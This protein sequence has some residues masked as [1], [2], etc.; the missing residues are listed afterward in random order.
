MHD[1]QM[2]SV[3]PARLLIVGNPDSVHVGSHFQRAAAAMQIE[4]RVCDPREA[5]NAPAWRQKTDW[6]IRGHRP[7]RLLQ[8]SGRVLQTVRSF[9]PDA[10]LTTGIAPVDAETLETIGELGS[11]RLNFLTDDPWNP[12]HRAPWFLDALPAY[13]HVFTPRQANVA[14]LEAAGIRG[15][16]ILPFAYA[17]DVH[18]PETAP[19]PDAETYE[20]DVMVAGGGDRDRVE[21]LA[22]LIRAGYRVA[23]YGGYWER[24][25][26]TRGAARGV[27]DAPGLRHATAA[28]KICL[29][30]VRRANRDGHCMRTY[31]VP[32]MGGCL[33]AEDT[34]DHRGLFGADGDA[35]AYFA[36]ADDALDKI[37]ALVRRPD[38]RQTL[39][40]RAHAIVT[41]GAH[42][43]ADR[44]C[45]IFQTVE[46]GLVAR[47]S[48][49][50]PE[51]SR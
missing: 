7:S 51:V 45:R 42:T 33:V 19:A 38:L 39:A 16:S 13:D 5:Y 1:T 37:A 6:W 21:M 41:T 12:A 25:R 47:A 9:A 8:F 29:G 36:D 50:A 18:Y 40:Q 30:L 23:L 32:A 44:L 35:V 15:V 3:K 2:P 10:V 28:A 49:L 48:S 46:P 22:P 26:E 31:E 43:Y 14:D 4:T 17:P 34:P 20:A 11:L 24:F 27:V